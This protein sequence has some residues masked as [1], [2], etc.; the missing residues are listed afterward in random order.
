MS[1]WRI[2]SQTHNLPHLQTSVG[3]SVFITFI[4]AEMSVVQ[5]TPATTEL[6]TQRERENIRLTKSKKKNFSSDDLT[7]FTL[8]LCDWTSH[9]GGLKQKAIVR[10]GG[11]GHVVYRIYGDLHL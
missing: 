11:R 9:G 10:D 8:L 4:V 1:L 2:D 5:H 6:Y 7:F 3:C